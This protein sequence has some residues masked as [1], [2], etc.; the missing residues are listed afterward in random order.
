[1]SFTEGT[2][3]APAGHAISQC[4]SRVLG[5][6][7]DVASMP[8]WSM[9]LEE[10]RAALVDLTRAQARLSE[11][12]LRVLAAADNND[13]G[14][15]TG[16]SS[17][18]AWLAHETKQTRPAANGDVRLA[19][20][21]DTSFEATRLALAEGRVNDKQA[22]V[23]VCA[24]DDLPDDVSAVDRGRAEAFLI[25]AAAH[26]DAKVL[27]AMGKR[28]FEVIDPETAD[29]REGEKLRK[30]EE[31]ARRK[32]FFKMRDNGDGTHSGFFKLPT[33]HAE[34]LQKM[35]QALTAPRRI[36]REGRTDAEGNKLPYPTLLG[37]G[38]MELIERI[39]ADKL[40]QCGGLSSTIVVTI[41]LDQL[42]S[43]LG[44]AKLDTGGKISAGEA[45]RLACQAG[46]IPVVLDGASVPVD[47][48][49]EQRFHNKY[50]R[51]CIQVRDGGCTAE[52]CDRPP[53]WCECH[54]EIPWSEGGG[55]SVEKGRMLCWWHHHLAH[56]TG[57][58]M[59]RLANGKVRYRRRQ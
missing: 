29:E 45:R 3:G 59:T 52:N 58:T 34:S 10:Q 20:Q 35:L 39:S 23:I 19:K 42:M 33:L 12:R 47:I 25:E 43:G 18:G 49:R 41:G 37:R 28:L 2:N 14:K 51:I 56:D 8:T 9:T 50:Q 27:R 13:V 46:I 6:L 48:G 31:E 15:D 11:L 54:H 36:G 30:E 4:T 38:F 24:I 22:Q 32:A 55:T 21:L 16:C 40:P 1:M 53:G 5:A 26:W 7:G 17:T 57:Y 44:T